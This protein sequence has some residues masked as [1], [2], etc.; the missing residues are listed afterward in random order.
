M[1][2]VIQQIIGQFELIEGNDLLHPLRPFRRGV[3]VV[4]HPPGG[5]RVGFAGHQPGGAVE[6]VP[7]RGRTHSQMQSSG[8]HPARRGLAESGQGGSF[9]PVPPAPSCPTA[10]SE[11]V[12]TAKF[13]EGRISILAGR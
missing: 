9:I 1:P 4:V 7:A 11:L 12:S 8:S 13:V 5:G 2:V 10:V 3:G 6:G